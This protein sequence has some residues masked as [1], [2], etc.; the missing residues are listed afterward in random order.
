MA[1]NSSG[2][3]SISE[4]FREAAVPTAGIA[5]RAVEAFI[6]LVVCYVLLYVVAA[7]TGSTVPSAR[8]R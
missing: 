1:R 5:L 3:T 2:C 8:A 4:V 7:I 6:D